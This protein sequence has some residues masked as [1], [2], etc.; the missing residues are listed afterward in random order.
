MFFIP[1]T[2]PVE[3][4]EQPAVLYFKRLSMAWLPLDHEII[5]LWL[6]FLLCAAQKEF[7][8]FILC[9][10]CGSLDH[11]SKLYFEKPIS[12]FLYGHRLNQG[13]W[14]SLLAAHTDY[15]WD[16]ILRYVLCICQDNDQHNVATRCLEIWVLWEEYVTL[17]KSHSGA[18]RNQY[19][20]VLPTLLHLCLFYEAQRIFYK[21]ELYSSAIIFT[22]YN[23]SCSCLSW[24]GHSLVWVPAGSLWPP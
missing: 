9:I 20:T 7:G 19:V 13:S 12:T 5:R 3:H 10:F 15:H 16:E 8:C 4:F 24:R 21:V 11:F 2:F 1:W 18:I 17:D 6:M 23:T 14:I 22:T